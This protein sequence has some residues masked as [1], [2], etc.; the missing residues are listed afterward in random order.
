MIYLDNAAT[1]FPKPEKVYES[2]IKA[3]RNAFNIGRGSY[4]VAR[5]LTLVVDETR[6]KLLDLGN[7]KNGNVVFTSSATVALNNILFGIEFH[8]GDNV[9]VTPFE[10]N[11]VMRPLAELEKR[12]IITILTIPF[13]K[14]TWEIDEEKMRNMFA[15]NK[16]KAIV[17]SHISNS[18]GL[19]LP[20]EKIFEVSKKYDSI[21]ILD[22]A[23]G[24]GVVPIKIKQDI[25]YIVVAGHKSLY[26]SFGIAGY[27]KLGNDKLIKTV[28][29]GTGSDS[30][31]NDMPGFE[32]GSPN[33]VAIQSIHTS[34][35][36]VKDNNIFEH[37]KELTMYLI[38]ELNKI[39]KCHTYVPIDYENKIFGIV[40]FNIEGYLAD[41]VGKILDE[42][43][44]IY[45]RTGFH[46]APQIHDFISSIEYNG[47]VR[48]SLGYFNTK[49]DI[50]ELIK[51]LKSL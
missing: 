51:A 22:S 46:C 44:D 6:E 50:D 31:N 24:Y 5:E 7:I 43:Y 37:E 35:D 13:Y 48:V 30:L 36:W 40:S 39:E 27:I 10:H 49:K 3:N 26:G 16:P 29:G 20:F 12:K 34:I 19:I 18:T 17:V 15:L 28:F 47:T 1:T 23:Q 32:A 21:N 41:D 25:D 9:Y 45:V 33:I 38:N 8:E 11:A 4:K 42:E 2:I 14:D